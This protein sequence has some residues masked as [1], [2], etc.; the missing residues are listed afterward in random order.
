MLS[1]HIKN[2]Y[3]KYIAIFNYAVIILSSWEGDFCIVSYARSTYEKS[4][5]FNNKLKELQKTIN[6]ITI[7]TYL[8]TKTSK[9]IV[10]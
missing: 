2:I 1:H 5:I 9:K 4:K 10:L 3:L 7:R 8:V 6:P